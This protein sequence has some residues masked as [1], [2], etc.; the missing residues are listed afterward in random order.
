VSLV[1]STARR[2]AVIALVAGLLL[3]LFV[4]SG[5]HQPQTRVAA[6]RLGAYTPVTGAIFNSPVGSAAE[7]R[8]IF[9]HVNKTIDATPP[10]A[11]IRFAVFS[12]SEQ[13]TADKLIAAYRRG[14]NVQLIFDDHV[15]YPQEARL[16]SVIGRSPNQR[17][18][19]VLCHKSCRGTSG[20]MHDKVFLFSQAGSASNVVMV[21]SN[22]MTRHN[23]VDQ[24]SDIYT[25][26][27]D[28]ALYFTYSGVFEQMKYDRPMATPYID[29]NVNGYGPQFYPYPGV[30]QA[31]DPLYQILSKVTCTG[32][33]TETRTD[34][35]GNQTEVE[36]PVVTNLR[37]SQHAW[38]GE[39]GK[40]LA[41]KVAE[42]KTSGCDIGVIYGVGMGAAVKTILESAGIP[43]SKGKV[44]G[45]RTHQKTL[46]LSG[47][48]DG[49][50]DARIVWTG[51]HNWSDGALRRDEIIF[52][53]E[54]QPT[55][56]EYLTNW[57]DI[58][59]NG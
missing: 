41:R 21:G 34:E 31:T 14:V 12:F 49:D 18:F 57:D 28:P 54:G 51:S 42:L 36:V 38:N 33:T 35:Y 16:R 59:T 19:V 58:W 47:I 44:K 48:Y 25:V 9:T 43:M 3:A 6:Q 5:A 52:K 15:V 17:S 50:P 24:W 7:Q 30:T 56:D 22:N 27:G 55:Y 10:G 29:A 40:Y 4:T 2:S 39:R 23:A 20:N 32:T 11:T 37:I 46:L 13:A 1:V 26:V 53:I 45:V 8:A